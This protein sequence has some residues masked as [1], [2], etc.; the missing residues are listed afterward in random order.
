MIK[1]Y[2]NTK[3][4]I[5]KYIPDKYSRNIEKYIPDK[6]SKYTLDSKVCKNTLW[7]SRTQSY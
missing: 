3:K 7:K 4:Y 2:T 5:E 6:Y 1:K